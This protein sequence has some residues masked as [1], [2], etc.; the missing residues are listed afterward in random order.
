MVDSGVLR[1]QIQAA[2]PMDRAAEALQAFQRGT[3]GKI[4]LTL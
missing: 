2:Y 1:V 3:H 4:V